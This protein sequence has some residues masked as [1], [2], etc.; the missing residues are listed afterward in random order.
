MPQ[1]ALVAHQHYDNVLIGMVAQLSQPSLD[2][3]VRQMFGNVVDKQRTDSTTIVGGRNGTVSLLA[4]RIPNLGFDD[5]IIDL[6]K[7]VLI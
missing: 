1:I 3:L 2:I 5:L 4:G 7:S 6:L